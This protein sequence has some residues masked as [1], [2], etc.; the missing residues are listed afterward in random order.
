[1][2]QKAIRWLQQSYKEIKWTVK[3]IVKY[4][5]VRYTFAK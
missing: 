1:M 4:T 5:T 3:E 2:E